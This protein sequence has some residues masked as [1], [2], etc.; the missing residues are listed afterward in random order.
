MR[1]FV[2]VLLGFAFELLQDLDLAEK[3]GYFTEF[4]M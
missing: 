3:D 2:L 4:V 1:R